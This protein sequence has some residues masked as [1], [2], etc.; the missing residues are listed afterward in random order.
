MTA[1]QP[2]SPE[3]TVPRIE[4]GI[5]EDLH[6]A[7]LPE[8]GAVFDRI[9]SLHPREVLVDLSECR[10]IDA[11]AISLLL[12]VHRRLTRRR[13]VLTLRDPNPRIRTILRTARLDAALPIVTTD[14][15]E[16]TA[17]ARRPRPGGGALS[18][19]HGRA[20]VAAPHGTVS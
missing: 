6:L 19:V 7:A 10:H 13:A 11:A 2:A 5:T 18:A 20:R 9:L 16:A 17:A 3:C 1:P 14:A 15:A 4:V 8:I 12:D